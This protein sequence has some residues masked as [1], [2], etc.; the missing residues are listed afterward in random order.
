[1]L[2]EKIDLE[3]ELIKEKIRQQK[4]ADSAHALLDEATKKDELILQR[5]NTTEVERDLNVILY[6]N[7]R[8][9]I[10]SISE[11][12]N[13]CIK[14]RLR[15]LDSAHFK[16][17]YPYEAI[18]R[19]KNFETKYNHQIKNFKVIAPDNAFQ[20]EELNKDP[21]LF[22]QL[23]DNSFY[24]I[25][26]W[27]ND[28]SWYKKYLYMPLRSFG[29]YFVFLWMFA[30]F[31]SFSIPSSVIAEISDQRELILRIWLT[32]HCVIGFMGLSLWMGLSF[33]INFSDQNWNNK[34]SSY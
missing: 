32:I 31:L 14:Y 21:L 24:L 16:S 17:P 9:R 25:H 12:K 3:E 33:G 23:N 27:G 4:L 30:A 13:L 11:I 18:L 26:K 15:F 28:L 5:L 6:D 34:Y 10:F 20:L 29:A 1:M 22:A 19:I 8:D 2:F 7:D